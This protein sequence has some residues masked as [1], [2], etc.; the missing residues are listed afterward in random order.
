MRFGKYLVISDGKDKTSLFFLV[1]FFIFLF[2]GIGNYA[3]SAALGALL[4]G[5]SLKNAFPKKLIGFVDS[6]IRTIAYGFF[7][8]VFFLSIGLETDVH[9][10]IK[11]PLLI[12]LVMAMTKVTKIT[13]SYIMGRN[14]LGPKKSIILGI[15]LCV[16]FSTSLVILKLLLDNGMIGSDLFSVLIGTTIAFKFIVPFLM[17]YF[18]AIWGI[19]SEKKK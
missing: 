8:P 12:L 2:V 6:E 17:S 19:D 13:V 7:A 15:G 16:K 14:V 18:I 4:A 11:F 3:E 5:I 10:L 9:Y 1:L